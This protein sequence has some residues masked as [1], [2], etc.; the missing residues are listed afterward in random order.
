MNLT[1]INQ[2]NL[3]GLENKLD[4]LY[5]LFKQNRL[6]NKILLSG[7]KGC[8][9]ATMA[10]HLINRIL[11]ENEEYSYNVKN[12]QINNKNK[13]FKLIQNFTNPNFHLVDILPDK[14]IIDINQI[15]S[16]IL[17]LNKSSFNSKPRFVLIDN[18]EFL[19][20]SSVNALLKILEEPNDNIY[21]I[22]INNGK[23]ILDTLKS[24]CLDFKIS[25][26]NAKSI[27]IS[28]KLLE[29]NLFELINKNLINYYFTPGNVLNLIK[30]ANENSLDLKDIDLKNFLIFL[31]NKCYYKK[32]T[33]IKYLIYDF[34]EL[35]IRNCSDY[36]YSNKYNY[37]LKR[38][39]EL[40]KYNLDDESFFIEFETKI[41]NV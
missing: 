9:K 8:G 14:K 4:D 25:F 32:E 22:L 39:H 41:L 40:K 2:I 31:I 21:F 7:Q 19:N 26:S 12:Y 10:F 18:I 37:F 16:L 17:D 36:I 3:Y 30:F 6:P 20:L 27:E 15:R 35:F 34:L 13:S 11:S 24:R 29:K 1:P 38:I 5:Y 33:I 28:N 23:K